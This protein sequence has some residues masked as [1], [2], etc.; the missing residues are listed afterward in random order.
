MF[1]GSEMK[2]ICPVCEIFKEKNW[3]IENKRG[4]AGE[5]RF[6]DQFNKLIVYRSGVGADKNEFILQCPECREYF[7]YKKWLQAGEK[8][9][10]QIWLNEW[11]GWI[12]ETMVNELSASSDVNPSSSEVRHC[13]KCGSIKV[14]LAGGGYIGGEAFLKMRCNSCGYEDMV[15]EY[16]LQDWC[17]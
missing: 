14:C 11:V 10:K 5:S 9:L 17:S 4:A 6:P 3:H 12:P 13:P 2:G 8:D 16:Q 1:G 15:D 7:W